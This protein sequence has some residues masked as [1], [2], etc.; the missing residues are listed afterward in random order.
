MPGESAA[1]V[2]KRL[3]L[4]QLCFAPCFIPA[5]TTTMLFLEG[6][7]SP[8]AAAR[9]Q[10]GSLVVANWK[11]WVPAQL[12]NFGLVPPHFQVLFANGVATCWNVYLS[13]ATHSQRPRVDSTTSEGGFRVCARL[14]LA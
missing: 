2:G 12:I 10:W 8:L 9:E 4:D 6:A 11:L 13:W 1:A 14:A 5:F 7:P 3:L